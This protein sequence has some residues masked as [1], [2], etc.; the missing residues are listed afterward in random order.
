MD[1]KK[2]PTCIES[3]DPVLQ[4]GFPSGSLVLLLGEI[5]AGEFEFAISSIARL[6]NRPKTGHRY[7]Q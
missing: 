6:L 4:G 1:L 5:G 7:A 3:L 2:N